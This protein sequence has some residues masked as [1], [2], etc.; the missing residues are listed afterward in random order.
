VFLDSSRGYDEKQAIPDE[1]YDWLERDLQKAEGMRIYVISHVPPTDPRSG[2]KPNEIDAYTD[3][4]KQEGGL[5]EQKLEAYSE[6]ETIDHG[7]RD[8]QEAQNFEN[9]MSSIQ[10]DHRLCF[11]YSQLF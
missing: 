11:A 4:V 9:L 10:G 2:V 7:F 5:V 1:Q 6:D 8:K 3:K